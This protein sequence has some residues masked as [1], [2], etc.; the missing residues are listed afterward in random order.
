MGDLLVRAEEQDSMA[1]QAEA[2]AR[3]GLIGNPSDGYNGKTISLVIREFSAHVNLVPSDRLEFIP[4]EQDSPRYHSITEFKN[5]IQRNGYYGAERLFK[6]TLIRFM[7][8]CEDKGIE[9]D[10]RNFA[11]NYGS[12]IPWRVGMAGSSALITAAMRCLME[13][14][15]VGI[16]KPEL[17]TLIWQVEDRYLGISAGLQDRVIQVYEGCLFMDFEKEHLDEH[18][19]GKYEEIDV[20]MLPNL[21]IAYRLGVTEGSEVFHNNIRERWDSG[22]QQVIDAMNQFAGLAQESYDLIIAGAGDEIGPLMDQNFE[23]RKSLYNMSPGDLA[24]IETA[25]DAGSHCK[26]TGSG[27]AIIG[28]YDDDDMFDVLENEFLDTDAV[29]LK[30]D[31]DEDLDDE[32]F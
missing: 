9:L 22:D 24:M 26:F 8:Y 17:P 12:T 21:F 29:L 15:D 11:L 1:I 16:P 7:Q 31:S 3:A 5:S 27:G 25:R 32:Y 19:Y 28:T 20:E 14:Y 4:N 10:D 18:G 23:L 2:F 30:L 13:F 6:A